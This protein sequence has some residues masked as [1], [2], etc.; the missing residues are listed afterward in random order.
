MPPRGTSKVED[1]DLKAHIE[2]EKEEEEKEDDESGSEPDE[3]DEIIVPKYREIVPTI[4]NEWISLQP[5]MSEITNIFRKCFKKGLKCLNKTFVRWS[6]HKDLEREA[7]I[8]EDWD[9]EEAIAENWDA[10]D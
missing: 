3:A 10:P 5:Q 6:K 8:L 4:H 1:F 9:W 7:A 2:F